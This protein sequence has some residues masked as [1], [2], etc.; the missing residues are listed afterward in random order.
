MK[1]MVL[2][3]R[4]TPFVLENVPDPVPGEGEA[5]AKVLACGAGLTVHHVR[6][7]RIP[8]QYPRIIGHE[9][10]GEIVALGPGV[11]GLEVGDPVTAY[12]YL[13]CG[14][15]YWCRVNRET[16][17]DNFRGYVGREVDGGY[18]EYIKLPARNFLKLPPGLDWRKHPA[19]V[20]VISDAIATPV[21]VIRRARVGPHDTVAVFGA[22]GGLGVHMTRVARWAHARKVIAVDV[23]ASK[24]EACLK[25]GA[26]ATVDASDGRVAEQ[27]LELTGGRGVDVAIDFV[28]SRQTL[29]AALASLGKGGRLVSLGGN[30]QPFT[31]DPAQAL[32]KEVEIMGSR[33][34]TRQEVLDALELVAR[35][36]LFPMVT[37]KA[38]LEQAEAVHQ[39]LDKGLVTGRA[40]LLI[41]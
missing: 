29:E 16:L 34:A 22:G 24:F 26:D 18:A 36:E 14:D 9:I 27:L 35:G 37:E 7:G 3:S 5:V 15:C 2:K 31:V 38:P 21:K 20:G 30:S 28:S 19:E 12:F 32:R 40:A 11:S 23:M 17:C 4:G 39:R 10:T 6:A 41:G 8:V 33:Y 13:T 25:A 1:A